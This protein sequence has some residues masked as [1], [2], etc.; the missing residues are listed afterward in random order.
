MSV[1]SPHVQGADGK[2]VF[3]ETRVAVIGGGIVGA[4]ISYGLAR[5]GEDVLLLN[6]GD[7]AFRASNGNF[8]LVWVQGKGHMLDAYAPWA[9]EGRHAWTSFHD[10]LCEQTGVDV[11]PELDGGFFICFTEEELAERGALLA[12][13]ATLAP[14]FEFEVMPLQR[15]AQVMPGLREVAGAT[16]SRLDGAVNPLK[17][18]LALVEGTRRLGGKLVTGARVSRMRQQPGGWVLETQRG[19]VRA[20]KVVL[21]AGLGNVPLCAQLGLDLPVKPVRGQILVTERCPPWLKYPTELVRQMRNGT[22]MIGGSWEDVG[23]DSGTTLDVTQRIARNATKAFPYLDNVKLVRS[24]GALR[25]LAPDMAPVYAEPAPG[26]FLVTCHSGVSLAAI[27]A[28]K[29]V[30]WIR[31]GSLAVNAAKFSPDRFS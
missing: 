6:E 26:A 9:L 11:E 19:V 5:A 4:S 2:A 20:E 31:E 8:G 30:D 13:L 27:H 15:A 21:A 16:W 3:A 10:E 17:L 25:I 23:F 7:Q 1:G 29:I 14:G 28:G 12:R 22:L 24:W 18:L